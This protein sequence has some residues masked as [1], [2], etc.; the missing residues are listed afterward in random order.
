MNLKLYTRQETE[1]LIKALDLLGIEYQ[2][3]YDVRTD[4][5]LV[6]DELN[7]KCKSSEQIQ[8]LSRL[9][10]YNSENC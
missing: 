8:L 1:F 2:V 3:K 9:M 4:N 5:T 7:F 10:K 6:H